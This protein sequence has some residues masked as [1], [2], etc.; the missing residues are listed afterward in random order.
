MIH[1]FG[2]FVLPSPASLASASSWPYLTPIG[3][4]AFSLAWM[5]HGTCF[6]W[7]IPL[8]SLHVLSDGT[9]A[10]AYFSMPVMLY[11]NRHW[12]SETVRPLLLLFAAFIFSCG[13][14]HALSIWNIWHADYWVSGVE[15]ALT[16]IISAVSAIYLYHHSPSLLGTQKALENAEHMASTDAL[17]GLT[18]RRGM[19]NTI[20]KSM[21]Q[22]RNNQMMHS[23]I[24]LDLDNFKPINDTFGHSTGDRILKQVAT[25]LRVN[26]RTLDTAARLGGDEFALFLPGCPLSQA[27]TIATLTQQAI[28]ALGESV[29]LPPDTPP[30]GCSIGIVTTTEAMSLFQLY[31]AA[32]QL[33]YVSKQRGKNQISAQEYPLVSDSKPG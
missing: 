27:Q 29:N 4:S 19:D 22:L 32:D 21:A 13:I 20:A 3:I 12:A 17:T 6:F 16:G 10:L 2:T 28:A 24:L 5:P 31:D 15:K 30:F 25:V 23:L 8:T 1:L 9:I 33:L 14:S 26:I 11:C 7:N 18:N